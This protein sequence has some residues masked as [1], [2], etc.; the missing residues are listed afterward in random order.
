[1]MDSTSKLV[2]VIGGGN[3]IGAACCSVMAARGWKVAVADHHETAAIAVA[4]RLGTKAYAVNVCDL[5]AVRQLAADIERD[6]GPVHS[7]VMSA[8]AFQERIPAVD[9]PPERWR[10]VMQ[11]NVEG[12]FN[13][14]RVFGAGM[15]Q[16]RRGSIVNVA[17]TNAHCSTPLHSYGPSKAAIVSLTRSLAV[18]WGRSG[19]RVN[20][21]SPGATLVE[22]VLK[23]PPGRYAVDIDEQMALGRRV[24]PEE[25]AEGIEFLAS[26]RAS[27]ITGTDL[28]ID[29]GMIAANGWNIYGGVP[30]APA[31]DQQE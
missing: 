11:V 6:L 19:V 2:V 25:V 13:T 28:L 15:V 16:R 24:Q 31:S 14:N 10:H 21:V 20:S 1:M 3:G 7:L 9:F 30:N 26:D 12:T 8:G 23:R 27:A 22:R 17:S 29:A 5:D 4:N 18:E